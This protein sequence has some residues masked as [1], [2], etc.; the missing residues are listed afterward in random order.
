MAFQKLARA[1][2]TLALL[3]APGIAPADTPP[4]ETVAPAFREAIPNIPGKS[5]I[6][7]VVDYAPGGKTPAHHHAHS[8]FVTGY[9]LSGAIRSEVDGGGVKVFHA[10]ESWTEQ[11]GAHHQVSENASTTEPAKLLAIFVVDTADTDLTTLEK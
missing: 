11:P 5:L 9:V 4:R 10:G 8:A 2:A 7:I 6:A 3:A 1:A